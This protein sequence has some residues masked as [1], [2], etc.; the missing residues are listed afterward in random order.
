MFVLSTACLSG[1]I[2]HRRHR[3]RIG[4]AVAAVATAIAATILVPVPAKAGYPIQGAILQEY[5]EAGGFAFFGE[6]TTEERTAPDGVGKY[7]F[8]SNTHNA[9]YW[10]PNVSGGHAN[11]IGGAILDKWAETGYESGS[12]GYPTSREFGGGRNSRGNHFQRGEIYWSGSTGAHVVNGEIWQTW[13]AT[14]YENGTYG[15]PVTDEYPFEDGMKQD[16]QDGHIIWKPYGFP[17]DWSGDDDVTWDA[18]PNCGTDPCALDAHALGNIPAA[19]IPVKLPIVWAQGISANNSTQPS[20]EANADPLGDVAKM[21]DCNSF[22]ALIRSGN[23]PST[24]TTWCISTGGPVAAPAPVDPRAVPGDPTTPPSGAATTPPTTSGASES[25]T[26]S[27]QPPTTSVTKTPAPT[28]S[29]SQA[30]ESSTPTP[31]Y[32]TVMPT[33]TIGGPIPSQFD[34]VPADISTPPGVPDFCESIGP[35]PTGQADWH[36]NSTYG[37]IYQATVEF[38]AID[39]DG[40]QVGSVSGTWERNLSLKYNRT[41][42]TANSIFAITGV[43]GKGVGASLIFQYNCFIGIQPCAYTGS[44]RVTRP[45]APGTTISLAA[46]PFVF[47]QPSQT[48][49]MDSDWQVIIESPDVAPG[50]SFAFAPQVRCDAAPFLRNTQGCAFTDVVPVL[51]YTSSQSYSEYNAHVSAAQ[52]S[53]LPGAYGGNPLHR[54]TAKSAI[55]DHRRASCGVVTGPRRTGKSC[56]EYPMASTREGAVL[57]SYGRTYTNPPCLI[58]DAGLHSVADPASIHVTSGFSVCNISASQNSS[59]GSLLSWFYTKNRIRDGDPFHINVQGS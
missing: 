27:K 46:N 47:T 45:V 39:K 9:I 33:H 48:L 20:D 5:N 35:D 8:F 25:G 15:L 55:D 58:K 7:Q 29:S 57:N 44:R 26:I 49:H 10:H 50:G 54:E 17:S 37:C 21:L 36:G 13:V 12:L 2:G 52:R 34:G 56:D 14:G 53:G 4:G 42:W 30:R 16:F 38:R 1:R 32:T 6:A 22:E 18:Q 11:Q 40:K 41:D 43:S 28:P 23:F 59:A 31:T 3:V 24:E 19:K 51:D